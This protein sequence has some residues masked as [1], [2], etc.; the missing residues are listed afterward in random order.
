MFLNVEDQALFA[1]EKFREHAQ[2]LMEHGI[3]GCDGNLLMKREICFIQHVV[4]VQVVAGFLEQ[5][6]HFSKVFGGRVL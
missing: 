3:A 4:I 1:R 5:A 2:Q 6:I